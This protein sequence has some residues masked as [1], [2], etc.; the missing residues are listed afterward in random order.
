MMQIFGFGKRNSG[1]IARN[2]LKLVL[3]ADQLGCRPGMLEAI[4]DDLIAVLS[5]YAEFDPA[6]VDISLDRLS[7]LSAKVPVLRLHNLRNE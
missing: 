7:V 2:R 6:L 3:A 5:R 4:R 1:A